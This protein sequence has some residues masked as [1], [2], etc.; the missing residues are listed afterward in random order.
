MEGMDDSDNRMVFFPSRAVLR[1]V[2]HQHGVES[3][4]DI[5]RTTV[6]SDSRNRAGID[7]DE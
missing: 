7:T 6:V 5:S 4:V 2:V 1:Y 3:A